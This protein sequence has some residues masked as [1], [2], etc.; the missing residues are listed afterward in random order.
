MPREGR[1]QSPTLEDGLFLKSPWQ[2]FSTQTINSFVRT[3]PLPCQPPG[4]G[5]GRAPCQGLLAPCS[6]RNSLLHISEPEAR[7]PRQKALRV[8]G[9]SCGSR[10]RRLISLALDFPGCKMRENIPA[11]FIS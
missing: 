8:T 11:A 3:D 9:V 10:A 6:F 7:G 2:A 5:L 4:L 1:G